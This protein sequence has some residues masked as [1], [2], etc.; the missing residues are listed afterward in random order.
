MKTF[1]TSFMLC[2]LLSFTS[3]AQ[4]VNV[5]SKRIQRDSTG[6]AG[7]IGGEFNLTKNVNTVLE[8]N[9][10]AT[11]Q[12]KTRQN[13]YLIL[14]DYSFMRGAD[15]RLINKLFAHLRYDH[16]LSSTT[17]LES[18][19]QFQNNEITKINER[20]LWGAGLR[21]K[22]RPTNKKVLMFLGISFMYELEEED[23]QPIYYSRH[24]RNSSYFTIHWHP[25]K[26]LTLTSSTFLQPRLDKPS[27]FRIL[28]QEDLKLVLT[29]KLS[30]TA[31]WNFVFDN[32]P[33]E[34]IPKMNYEL[35]TGL[36]YHLIQ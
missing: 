20:L 23:V 18:F 15:K 32:S 29:K 13:T 16:R 17:Y 25:N 5:E 11:L 28:N 35:T 26:L 36:E 10:Y 33:A 12:Y 9:L 31:D 2:L 22:L 6:W 27:D 1:F 14:G 19:F 3:A 30:F 4:I 34:G 7:N 8:T 24:F 21:F